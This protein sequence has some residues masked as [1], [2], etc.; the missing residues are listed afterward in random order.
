MR[1]ESG[2]G[3]DEMSI[4]VLPAT[5]EEWLK[6]RQNGIGASEAA[7]LLGM[8]HWKTN[9]ELWEEKVGLRQ[10]EDIS[11]KPY[12]QYGHDAEPHLRALFA[13]NHPELEVIYDSPF[14]IIRNEEHPFIFATP[15]GELVERET[16]CRG[17]LEIKTTEIRNPSQ[18]AKWKDR[19][20]DEYYSQVIWQMIAT[21]WD[22][23]ILN[24]QI[25]WWTREGELRLD[26]REYRINRNDV[27]E[28]I[29]YTVQEGLKF[30]KLVQ[31]KQRPAL[32]LPEI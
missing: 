7:A 13:L 26:V 15:D 14:K 32:K 4:I 27:L 1:S 28:D 16:G 12:V 24:A 5:H 18:W 3:N 17:G 8:S 11:D 31:T 30:W 19:I 25:R 20:P 2:K 23:V 10:P 6:E 22:F 21:D 29:E 9:V